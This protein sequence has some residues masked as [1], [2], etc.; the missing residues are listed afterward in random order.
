MLL[1]FQ[2]GGEFGDA[3][4]FVAIDGDTKLVP[5]FHVGRRTWTDTEIFIRDLRERIVNRPQI[6]TDAFAAYYGAIGL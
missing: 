3:Y 5:C 4:T 6:T 2:S 1:C